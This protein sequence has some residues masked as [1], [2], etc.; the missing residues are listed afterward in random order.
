MLKSMMAGL[1]VRIR[2]ALRRAMPAFDRLRR[3]S[4]LT[5]FVLA[6]LLALGPL[7]GTAG[8]AARAQEKPRRVLMLHSFNTFLPSIAMAAETARKR[9]SE[10]SREPIELYSE[11]LDL[12]RFAGEAHEL[13]MTRYLADKYRDRKPE[14][15]MVLGPQSLRFVSENQADLGFDVPIIFCCTSAARLAALNLPGNVTGILSEFD[16]T[17]TLALA[18]RLQPD[19]RQLVVIAGAADF[20]RQWAEVARRQLASSEQKYKTTYLVGL[21]HDALMRELKRLPRDTIAILLTMFSDGAGRLFTTDDVVEEIAN[22]ATAPVYA[23]Y[24][25]YLGRGI[26]GGH[27]D[28]F[29]RIGEEIGDLGLGILAGAGPGSL[30]PRHTSGSA[31]RVDW[32]QLKRWSISESS[33]PPNSE[34]RFREFSLWDRY[35]WQMIAVFAAVLLQAA[36]IAGLL[37]ERRR[38]RFAEMEARG[39]LREV[40]HLDRVA[41]VGAMSASIAH[42]LNQPLGAILLNAEA[43]ELLLEQ[44]PIDS[45]QIKQVL[46]GIRE[47]DQRAADIIAHLRGL[48]RKGDDT[49]LHEFDLNDALRGALHTMEPEARKRGVLMIGQ[50]VQGALPVRAS[51]VHL[52]QVVLN[53]ATNAMDAM[54]SCEAGRRTLAVQASPIG[55]SEVMVSISDSGPGIP[56]EKLDDIFDAFY[57]TKSHGT[58]LGLSI[59]RTIVMKYGGKIW[60]ENRSGG[61]A[62]FRFTLPLAKASPM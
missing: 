51:Q 2:L 12:G 7:C 59:V 1:V 21:P 50:P 40:I 41:T 29:E 17:R 36:L 34:V 49:E 46:A 44:N 53:L 23:P 42:E 6:C 62:V 39:R 8:D 61:G 3:A 24:E 57:S 26:V 13:L 28:S 54:E 35:R 27:M 10:R 4:H 58:G 15:I 19:A 33:L 14:A 43:A 18:Q 11:F 48:L 5:R 22:A 45:G 56:E 55:G 20:D 31:D 47:S 37:L 32:R 38:R 9:M 30:T 52:E 60:A 25:T 16:L